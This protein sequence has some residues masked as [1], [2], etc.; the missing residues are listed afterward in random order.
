MIETLN[1]EDFD[2]HVGSSATVRIDGDESHDL[3]L[4]EVVHIGAKM[5]RG[6]K[7]H[8]FSVLFSASKDLELEQQIYRVEHLELGEMDLFL[9]PLG[10]DPEGGAML[11][12]AVFT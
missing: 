4:E 3:K 1:K 7:R 12:E 5:A 11:F 10:P 8:A 6:A 2:A 9:V